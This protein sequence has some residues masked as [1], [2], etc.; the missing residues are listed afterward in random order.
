MTNQGGKI[1][2]G[3]SLG[4]MQVQGD[5]TLATGSVEL[6]LGGTAAGQFDRVAVTGALN[7]G[8]SLTLLLVNGFS[9]AAGQSFD[10]LDFTS[11]T[12]VFT[13]LN[14][15]TLTSGL[16]WNTSQLLSTGVLS[17]SGRIAR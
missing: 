8:G 11:S 17:V 1:A 6:E 12:G 3:R 14:L 15:P 4:A 16:S 9:P 13:A 5:L 10:V 2:P 7:A